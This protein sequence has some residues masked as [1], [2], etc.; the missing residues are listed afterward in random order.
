MHVFVYSGADSVSHSV[1]PIQNVGRSWKFHVASGAV[2]LGLLRGL[3]RQSHR[4]RDVV[5][6]ARLA[7]LEQQRRLVVADVLVARVLVRID[8]E[9][10]VT[11]TQGLVVALRPH[12][13]PHGLGVGDSAPGCPRGRRVGREDQESHE[14]HRNRTESLQ[15]NRPFARNNGIAATNRSPG[16]GGARS[17]D[18]TQA[19]TSPQACGSPHPPFQ[20]Q[21]APGGYAEGPGQCKNA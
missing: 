13:A 16:P 21:E 3:L 20:V 14:G 12:L 8:A 15:G 17:R 11:L 7:G 1:S 19:A 9:R 5:A 4:H 2:V 6:R 18:G 10:R